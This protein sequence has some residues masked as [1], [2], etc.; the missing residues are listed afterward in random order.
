[1]KKL[2]WLFSCLF[3]GSIFFIPF[4]DAISWVQN[5][6]GIQLP[7]NEATILIAANSS[8]QSDQS[9]MYTQ[10]EALYKE[11]KYDDVIRLLAAEA[12]ADPANFELN[13]LLAKAQ[14][15]K[16]AIMK[17]K[18]NVAYKT[19]IYQPYDTAQRFHKIR[20][21]PDLY[22]IAAKSLLI[23]NRPYRAIKTIKKALRFAPD[24]TDYL[25]VLAD[26]YC[27]QARALKK[28]EE[29]SYYSKQ[30]FS[31]ANDIYKKVIETK[32]DNE[33]FKTKIEE[34]MKRKESK[35]P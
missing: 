2:F 26:A 16:C 5:S 23:N 7:R 4:G 14:V 32:K 17:E 8:F 3:L 24:N 35:S 31:K 22:Y 21:H 20:A 13:I 19:L 11:H 29:D 27:A 34:K 28:N 30:L 33:E 18:G 6:D 12:Y 15:E 10:A 1:M 25:L 9:N